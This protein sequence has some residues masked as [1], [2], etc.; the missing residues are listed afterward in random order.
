MGHEA[1]LEGNI[2][3]C[4]VLVIKS[5]EKMPRGRLLGF[6]EDSTKMCIVLFQ[7]AIHSICVYIYIYIYIY[8]LL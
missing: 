1:L 7:P 6:G 5:E 8:S 4:D 2:N 3:A